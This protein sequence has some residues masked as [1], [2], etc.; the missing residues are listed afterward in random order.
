MMGD[1]GAKKTTLIVGGTGKTGKRVAER[2]T[3]KGL[4][5]RIG[6]RSGKPPF[7]WEDKR[8]WGPALKNLEAA[9]ITFYPDLAFPGASDA[10]HSFARLAVESGVRRLVLLSGRG[11]EGALRGEQAVRESGAEWTIVRASWFSQNFSEGFF[12]ESVLNGEVAFPAGDVREPFIDVEDIADVAAA[13]LTEDEHCRQLYEVTGPQLL[14]F[15][16]AV[17]EIAKATGR[18]IRYVSVPAEQYESALLEHGLRPDFVTP[19]MHLITTVLDGRNACLTDGL[20]RVL[21]SKPRTF[22]DYARST[23]ATGRWGVQK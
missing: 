7:D 11:E 10:V 20:R 18:E 5:V 1:A 13:A 6:S 4:A 22:A 17:A 15:A 2:L 21:E 14:T 19:F 12:L 16:E 23:A 3:K 8:T 9:Y